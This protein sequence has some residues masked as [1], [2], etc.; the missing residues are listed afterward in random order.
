MKWEYCSILQIYQTQFCS[1]VTYRNPGPAELMVLERNKEK[2][3][4][5]NHDTAGRMIAQL[6][7]DGWEMVGVATGDFGYGANASRLYFKRPIGENY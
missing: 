7:L 3:D 4:Q 1:L 5:S 6:G 2:Q